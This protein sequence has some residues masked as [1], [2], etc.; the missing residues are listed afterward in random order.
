MS[1]SPE[2]QEYLLAV[3]GR[4]PLDPRGHVNVATLNQLQNEDIPRLIKLVRELGEGD[5]QKADQIAGEGSKAR[6][7][8]YVPGRRF[9]SIP[10]VKEAIQWTGTNGDDVLKFTGWPKCDI[11]FKTQTLFISTLEGRMEAWP[12]DW[13]IKGLQGEFYPCKPAI[14]AASYEPV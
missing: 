6:W 9:R 3:E 13:V 5:R 8:E 10:K 11:D 14:F 1:L 2:I 7:G 12:G 4:K